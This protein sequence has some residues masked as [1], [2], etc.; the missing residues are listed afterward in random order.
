M[1]TDVVDHTIP[2][3]GDHKLFWN[4][5]NWQPSCR[6]HHDVIKQMLERKW[7][8]GQASD[9]DLRLDSDMAKALTKKH[10]KVLPIGEDGWPVN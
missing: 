7:E 2:H 10:P 8:V 1:S 5:A 6:Y 4:Q 3:K 9:R